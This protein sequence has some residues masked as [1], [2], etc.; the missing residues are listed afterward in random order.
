MAL[1]S[2]G[3]AASAPVGS[4]DG[5]VE[6]VG[7]LPA[8]GPGSE[9]VVTDDETSPSTAAT[10]TTLPPEPLIGQIV[11]GNRFL[12]IGDSITASASKRYGKELCDVLAPLGWRVEV[13]AEPSR[14]IDFG[15]SVLKKRWSAGWDAVYIFLGTNYLGDLQSYLKQLRKMLD[16]ISPAPVVLLTVTEFEEN[17]SEVNAAITLVDA[18]YPNVHV[19]DWASLAAADAATVLRGDGHHLTNAGRTELAAAVAGVMGQAPSQPGE[20]LATS[21]R[22]DSGGGVNGSDKPSKKKVG[23]TTPTTVAKK[24]TTS[25][26]LNPAGPTTTAAGGPTTTKP[27]GATSSPPTIP[28]PTNPPPT[29]PPPT[30]PPPT[31]PPPTNPPPTNPPPTSPPPTNP[32]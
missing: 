24:P 3:A 26:T 10:T 14:F 20:C 25:T 17:R 1:V 32:P 22:D 11:A 28:P 5:T 9:V 15:N 7:V 21:F 2:C 29:I 30:N 4:R 6:G 31:N 16:T 12:M 23:G 18:Q 13:D 19:L 8:S 27:P